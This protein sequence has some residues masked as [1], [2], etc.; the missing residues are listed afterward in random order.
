MK[1][2]QKNFLD[3]AAGKIPMP[4]ARKVD[5]SNLNQIP[6]G[7][8]HLRTRGF[9]AHHDAILAVSNEQASVIHLQGGENKLSYEALNKY[10]EKRGKPGWLMKQL[11]E[12]SCDYRKALVRLD[13]LTERDIKW[14]LDKEVC[15][16]PVNEVMTGVNFSDTK[17]TLGMAALASLALLMIQKKSE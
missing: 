6:N 7:I 11:P 16:N 8:H 15:E 14:S 5:Q 12:N 4:F 3:Q 1:P 10:L 17:R 13:K 9:P 2:T